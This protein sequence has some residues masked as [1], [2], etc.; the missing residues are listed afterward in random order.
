MKILNWIQTEIIIWKIARDKGLSTKQ[1]RAAM[2]EALD[3]AWDEAWQQGNIYGQVAWQKYFPGGRK[4]SLDEFI[5][6]LG[7]LYH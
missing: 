7:K 4:P 6:V 3:A 5:I 2:Q 1:I